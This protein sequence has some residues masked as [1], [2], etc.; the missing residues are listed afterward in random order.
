MAGTA[1]AQG[2][3]ADQPPQQRGFW[4]GVGGGHPPSWLRVC[5]F[6]GQ[7]RQSRHSLAAGASAVVHPRVLRF[8]PAFITGSHVDRVGTVT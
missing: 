1:E 6:G 7:R 3:C 8:P 4:D 5:R 2:G